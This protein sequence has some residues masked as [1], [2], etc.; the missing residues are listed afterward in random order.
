MELARKTLATGP[1]AH[2]PMPAKNPYLLAL[3]H[4]VASE[5]AVRNKLEEVLQPYGLAVA[6]YEILVRVQ[7]AGDSGIRMQDLTKTALLTSSGLTRLVDRLEQRGLLLRRAA[8]ADQRGRLCTISAAGLS[9]LERALPAFMQ[10]VEHTLRVDAKIT[11]KEL[12]VVTDILKRIAATNPE[13]HEE[14]D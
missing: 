12:A 1:D 8:S 2:F 4:L 3:V 11:R 13:W 14:T 7:K 5:Q 10:T 9:L 6:E